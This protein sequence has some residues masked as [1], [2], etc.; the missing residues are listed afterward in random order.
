VRARDVVF[1]VPAGAG[2]DPVTVKSVFLH[3]ANYSDKDGRSF[4]AEAT[5]AAKV[6]CGERTI[7]RTLAWLRQAGYVTAL[8]VSVA[9]TTEEREAH[10]RR[11]GRPIPARALVYVVHLEPAM[12]G[13]D[14]PAMGGRSANVQTGHGRP[15]KPA[16][17][18]TQTGHE[19]VQT[20]HEN[21]QTGHDDRKSSQIADARA[22]EDLEEKKEGKKE[23]R[24]KV[25]PTAAPPPE[26]TEERA[27]E[28]ACAIASRLSRPLPKRGPRTMEA[29]AELVTSAN[30]AAMRADWCT[31]EE[32]LTQ[33][34]VEHYERDD[35]DR[36]AWALS[37]A[38][39][40][41]ISV[42]DRPVRPRPLAR[43]EPPPDYRDEATW[44][45]HVER[46]KAYLASLEERAQA[47]SEG[48]AG[49]NFEDVKALV[50]I[51]SELLV[52]GR[53]C[54]TEAFRQKQIEG[55]EGAVERYARELT[56]FK[57]RELAIA[58]YDR[59]AEEQRRRREANGVHAGGAE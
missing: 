53:H 4:V 50:D 56:R 52:S 59:R 32:I 10:L 36:F 27:Y 17:G 37:L 9:Y 19:N 28:I 7:R 33:R 43:P 2:L 44:T 34:L 42:P 20:G 8:S 47:R 26:L 25:P 11:H 40:I 48:D 13:R 31:A 57:R 38:T 51:H 49:G 45:A 15:V 18:D 5:L 16:T 29:L 46:T 14:E 55:Y 54:I 12:G 24:G 30:D 41:P 22:L 58:A 21:V 35:V 6:H 39:Q 1:E 23:G 3:V